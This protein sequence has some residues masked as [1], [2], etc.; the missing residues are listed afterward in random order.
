M[1]M[2]T[3]KNNAVAWFRQVWLSDVKRHTVVNGYRGI[4]KY[5]LADIALRGNLFSS[6]SRVPGDV[7]LDG[8]NEGRRL[9]ALEITELARVDYETL[10]DLVESKPK[11][12][13][14]S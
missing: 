11:Q 8:V 1:T 10:F 3:L 4:N 12:E 13:R 7:F 9:L 6:P 5:T 2:K 14:K